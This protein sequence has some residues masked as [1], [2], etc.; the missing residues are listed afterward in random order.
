[1]ISLFLKNKT[2]NPSK[3]TKQI[4]ST[5][6]SL[7]P[8]LW[9]SLALGQCSRLREASGWRKPGLNSQYCPRHASS[10]GLISLI[11]FPLRVQSTVSQVTFFRVFFLPPPQCLLRPHH[12]LKE[13][14]I[15]WLAFRLGPKS[16]CGV[17]CFLTTWYSA[18]LKRFKHRPSVLPSA[19]A[20]A[21]PGLWEELNPMPCPW[22]LPVL[23]AAVGGWGVTVLL[24]IRSLVLEQMGAA[25]VCVLEESCLAIPQE[26][27]PGE[28]FPL[29][30]S[31]PHSSVLSPPQFSH[32][33]LFFFLV[34]KTR[35]G[36][37][38]SIRQ[39]SQEW[40]RIS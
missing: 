39:G 22:A 23:E 20:R 26:P 14:H 30:I 27:P 16:C 5:V 38:K 8:A 1:M 25:G 4:F 9:R 21:V 11:V 2:K 33:F 31:L 32:T 28:L 17:P 12:F 40:A 18:L 24:E 35:T 3:Q 13:K 36:K 19:G 15:A 37:L 34:F 7:F 10:L 29:I 6:C